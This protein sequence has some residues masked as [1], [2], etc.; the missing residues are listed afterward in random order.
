MQR[1]VST[2]IENYI[3]KYKHTI[4]TGI[5][6]IIDTNKQREDVNPETIE[7]I[8]EDLISLLQQLYDY[9]ILELEH[10]VFQKRKRVKN[11]V[12]LQHRC[13]AYRANGEQCTRK[14]K[15]QLYCGTHL[16]GT[17]HGCIS[18]NTDDETP[19]D[20]SIKV[21]VWTQDIGGIYYYIDDD[22]NVYDSNAILLNSVNPSVIAKYT[23]TINPETGETVY[24]IPEFNL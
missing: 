15:S 7:Q 23:K 20:E 5:I 12:E 14:K 2:A 8:N 11:V 18:V 17:P 6:K 13:T 24:N 4:K 16:K 22:Y 19:V 3:T 1:R 10:E 9:P 21:Q